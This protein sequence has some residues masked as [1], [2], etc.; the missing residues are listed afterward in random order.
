MRCPECRKTV[1]GAPNSCPHCGAALP[2]PK[3]RRCPICGAPVS[4]RAE[5]CFLCG[6]DLGPAPRPAWRWLVDLLVV[7]VVVGIVAVWY[8]L[9][10]RSRQASVALATSTTTA[11]RPL[12][13]II[14]TP[15]AVPPT[16]TPSW[17]ATPTASATPRPAVVTHK[18]ERGDTL[19]DLAERYGVSVA[20]IQQASGLAEGAVLRVGQVLTIPL[21]GPVEGGATGGPPTSTA[22]PYTYVVQP[23][24]SLSSIATRFGTTVT[25]L[26]ALNNL[27]SAD[28]LRAGQEL[29]VPGPPPP[30]GPAT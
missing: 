12:P 23:G 21:A 25:D 14:H 6:A 29:I 11:T 26:M 18:V 13:T 3:G 27:K 19:Y 17:T 8:F 1:E 24:D 2:R 30:P 5:Q 7:A 10:G 4:R 20:A 9:P 16:S 22:T 15:T 28:F